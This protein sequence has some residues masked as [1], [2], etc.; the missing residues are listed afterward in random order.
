MQPVPAK[1][2]DKLVNITTLRLFFSVIFQSQTKLSHFSQYVSKR[3]LKH[4]FMA[5]LNTIVRHMT[6]M[7]QWP[8]CLSQKK[9]FQ[10][11]NSSLRYLFH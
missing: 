7:F 4:T 11:K 3:R 2:R 1:A 6:E 10:R 5:S 8:K 9:M